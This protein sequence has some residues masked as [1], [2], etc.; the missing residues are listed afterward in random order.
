M[1][2]IAPDV[3]QLDGWP[4][5]AVNKYVIGDV[6]IDAGMAYEHKSV[7][8]QAR[9]VG[10]TAHALTHAHIDHYGGSSHV[11]RELGIPMWVGADDVEAVE[12]GKQVAQIPGR[13][14]RFVWAGA[15]PCKVERALVEG[16]EVGGFKVLDTPGHSPGHVSYWREGDRVLLL[17][18]VIWGWGAFRLGGPPRKPYDLVTPDPALN[19][20]SA[21]KLAALEPEV[22]CFGH[23]PVLRGASAFKAV[24]EGLG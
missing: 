13:G 17:G 3:L 4:N 11:L 7:I 14:R 21:R 23:G 8:R 5:N 15:K 18:D 2:E 22:V 6:L 20:A 10:V 9:E 19:L 1:R 16:D 24:V 12:R